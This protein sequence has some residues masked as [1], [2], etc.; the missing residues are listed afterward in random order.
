MRLLVSVAAAIW[1]LS[2]ARIVLQ[3]IAIA[4]LI[5]FLLTATARL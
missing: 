2:A 4:I 3:P 1:I 5:W